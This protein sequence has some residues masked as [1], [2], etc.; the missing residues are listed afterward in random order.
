MRAD[1][2]DRRRLN[3]LFVELC[4]IESPSGR[5]ADC[6]ARVRAELEGLGLA[7]EADEAGNLLARFAGGADATLMLCAHLDTVK[8]EA[9]VEPALVDEG[10]E[11][12]NDG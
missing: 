3:D 4:R 8:L 5:E 6:A 11:N 12:A 1:E 9:P 2:A 10:W 7:V